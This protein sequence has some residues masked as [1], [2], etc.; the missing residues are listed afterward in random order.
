MTDY[1]KELDSAYTAV[2]ADALDRLGLR[3]QTLDPAIR[4]LRPGVFVTGRVVP[5]LIE[6]TTEIPDEPYTGEMD[7][8][9]S[10]RP[11]EVPLL[12]VDPATRAASWGE[13]FSCAALGR[14]ARGAIV[15]GLIRDARQIA[16]LGFPLFCRGFSP[17]DTLGRAQVAA[18]GVTA[19]VGGVRVDPGD[20]VIGDEDGIVVVPALSIED[21]LGIVREKASTELDARADLLAGAGV[22]DIWA[23]YGVF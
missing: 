7:A 10:L 16:D 11:G 13:L 5:V 15:D 1:L 6:A 14:G 17:L 21:V 2:V 12:V 19:I 8:L 23:K 18:F 4:P 20:Y 3:D 9:D 22:R